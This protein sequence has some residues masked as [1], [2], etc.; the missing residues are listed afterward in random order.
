MDPSHASRSVSIPD[1]AVD[2]VLPSAELGRAVRAR[3]AT[4][5]LTLKALAAAAACSESLV[6]KI[7]NGRA[8]PSL[9]MLHRIAAA[10]RTNVAALVSADAPPAAT[11]LRAGRRQIVR[12]PSDAGGGIEVERLS[13]AHPGAMLQ[14]DIYHLAPGAGDGPLEHQGEEMGLVLDGVLT[15]TVGDERWELRRGDSF[16]FNSERPHG[17]F[18]H[19]RTLARILWVNTP[20]TF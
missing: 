18:N 1:A 4:L 17:F 13:F 11:V 7:E 8:T 19:G 14:A 12:F 15:L 9:V 16:V 6:S 20:P 2:A 10:L 5:G 3:R